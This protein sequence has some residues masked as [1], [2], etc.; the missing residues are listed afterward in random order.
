MAVITALL[1]TC[2]HYFPWRMALGR[3]LGKIGSYI[4]GVA[5]IC[6]PLAAI[7]IVTGY[8]QVAAWL[9]IDVFVAGVTVVG[10]Y[11]LDDWLHHRAIARE[12]L[13]REQALLASLKADGSD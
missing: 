6:G 9:A 3:D 10:C 11:G 5:S 1:L 7:L 8:M 2:G 12:A 4:Y 13:E